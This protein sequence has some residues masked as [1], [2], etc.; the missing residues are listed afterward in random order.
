MI[1]FRHI[2][3]D[4]EQIPSLMASVYSSTLSSRGLTNRPIFIH[5]LSDTGVMSY[6]GLSAALADLG[7]IKMD[8]RGVVWDSCMA[9]YPQVTLPRVMALLIVNYV[10]CKRDGMSTL[11]TV[12]NCYQILRERAWPNYIRRLKGLPVT[13]SMIQ[14]SFNYLTIAY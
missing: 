13:L 4:T 2:F 10:C 1:L 6:Q 5:C 12:K 3:R 8:I 14:G 11:S 9:P 7:N